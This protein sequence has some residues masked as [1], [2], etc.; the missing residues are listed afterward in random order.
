MIRSS[1]GW[2]THEHQALLDLGE[3]RA[4]L[5]LGGG[6]STCRIRW[7]KN[8]EPTKQIA[9]IAIV[10]G[11][12]TTRIRTPPVAGPPTCATDWRPCS[13]AL[14]SLIF[15]LGTSV[16]QVALVRHVEE[17]GADRRPPARRRTAAPA[18]ARRAPRPPAACRARAARTR[19]LATSTRPLRQRSTHAPAGRPITRNARNSKVPSSPIS[20]SRAPSSRI[21][22]TGSASTV[23][24]V[25]NWLIASPMKSWR[26]SWWR[27]SPPRSG[28]GSRRRGRGLTG[29]GLGGGQ[30]GHDGQ[31]A[32]TD[33]E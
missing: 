28:F 1:R 33:R 24:W 11:A 6:V 3:Q 30:V 5:G 15:S 17:H 22:S 32:P 31:G 29:R 23:S 13:L 12:P 2:R 26:K 4:A 8:A 9:S 25:P 14:P 19:S 10:S 16:G 20:N 21:A 27:N 18:S 7:T